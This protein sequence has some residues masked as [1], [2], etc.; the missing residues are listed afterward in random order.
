L[1]KS[2]KAGLVVVL[3]RQGAETQAEEKNKKVTPS[4]GPGGGAPCDLG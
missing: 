4:G 3:A 2:K 1:E